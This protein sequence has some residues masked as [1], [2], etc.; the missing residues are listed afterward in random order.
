MG[1]D[2]FINPELF[3]IFSSSCKIIIG[4]NVDIG[5][6]VY[7]A[8]GSHLIEPIFGHIAGKG[9]NKDI[10]IGNGCWIGANS[11]ILHG[12]IIG[13]KVVVASG[14]VVVDVVPTNTIIAG[15]PALVVK[16][17]DF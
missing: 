10:I 14:S 4:D 12:V 6:R 1:F 17:F 2:S 15:V 8:T 11:S 9:F 13:E 7:I 3:I 5:P 16:E